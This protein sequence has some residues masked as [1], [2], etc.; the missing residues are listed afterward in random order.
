M[1]LITF[2]REMLNFIFE[3]ELFFLILVSAFCFAVFCSLTSR[4][5]Y[6]IK[7]KFIDGGRFHD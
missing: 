5:Y 4:L 6:F 7:R 2:I 1:N 3:S